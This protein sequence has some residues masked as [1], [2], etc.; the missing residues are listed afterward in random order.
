MD[1]TR[2]VHAAF[3][4]FPVVIEVERDVGGELLAHEFF[5]RQAAR[6]G[7]GQR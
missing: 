7:G 3:V 5:R 1:L 6:L 4:F 2:L